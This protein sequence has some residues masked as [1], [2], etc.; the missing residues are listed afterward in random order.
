MA[1]EKS[2]DAWMA[3][4]NP[5]LRRLILD[6][7]PDLS[8][9]IKWGNPV[10]EKGGRVCYLSADRGYI[11]L[12]FFNATALSDPDGLMEGTGVKMR[13]VKVRSTADIRP[14][15]YSAWVREAMAL[16]QRHLV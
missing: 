7:C 4:V 1:A 12:G 2:V 6:A 15:S 8:E 10:Y 11:T 9:A 13:H 5:E 3:R 16:N 14:K